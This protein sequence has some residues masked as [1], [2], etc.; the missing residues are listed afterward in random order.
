MS[1]RNEELHLVLEGVVQRRDLYGEDVRDV[2]VQ[3]KQAAESQH[4]PKSAAQAL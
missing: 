2:S 4:M 3:D 1:H